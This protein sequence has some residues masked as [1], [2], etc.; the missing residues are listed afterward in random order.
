MDRFTIRS[1]HFPVRQHPTEKN[2][3]SADLVVY[4]TCPREPDPAVQLKIKKSMANEFLNDYTNHLSDQYKHYSDRAAECGKNSQLT[5]FKEYERDAMTVWWSLLNF[6]EII[7]NRPRFRYQGNYAK[8][9]L[10]DL[11]PSWFEIWQKSKLKNAREKNG[12]ASPGS[13]T[14]GIINFGRSASKSIP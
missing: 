13:N 7:L 10:R 1:N 3:L 11:N 8:R 4:T 6:Y 14:A 12:R 5:L 2:K 9:V